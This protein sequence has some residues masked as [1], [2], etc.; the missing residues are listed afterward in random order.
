MKRKALAAHNKLEERVN[1]AASDE[2]DHK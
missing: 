2:R 1:P